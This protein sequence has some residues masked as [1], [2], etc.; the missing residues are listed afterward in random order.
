MSDFIVKYWIGI[1]FGLIVTG[2]TGMCAKYRMKFIQIQCKHMATELGV[3]ALLRSDIIKMHNK[4][5][6]K[7]E[8]PIYEL[9]NLEDLFLQYENLGGNGVIHNLVDKVKALPV[10]TPNN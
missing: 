1:G 3:R 8:I 5:I 2:F 10:R 7:G 6:E 4:Y 9:E